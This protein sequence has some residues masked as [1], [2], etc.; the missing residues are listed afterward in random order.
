MNHNIEKIKN[1]TKELID[2]CIR[3]NISKICIDFYEI[4]QCE[5]QKRTWMTLTQESQS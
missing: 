5:P 4:K 3:C 1:S 2:G